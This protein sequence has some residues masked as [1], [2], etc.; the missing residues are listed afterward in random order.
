MH[1]TD[2][3]QL[4]ADFAH[5]RLAMR[6][7]S[8]TF[9][10]ASHLLPSDVAEG[11]GAV[12]AFCRDADDTMDSAPA[13]AAAL[14]TLRERLDAIYQGTP[15]FPGDRALAEIVRRHD[16]PRA[17]FEALLEGFAWEVEGRRYH[18]LSDLYAYAARVA[19]C[20]GTAVTLIMGVRDA[21]TLARACDLGVAMQ[22]TNV[23]RDVGE[24]A[25]AGRLFLPS[26]WL[27]QEGIDADEWLR[28]PIFSPTIGRLVARLLAAAD[29][30]YRRADAGISGLPPEC[31]PAIR[32][33]SR[34]YA[35]IG[36]VI[37]EAGHDSIS[38]RART[39]RGRK[40]WLT[41]R[42]WRDPHLPTVAHLPP[43]DEVRF[44]VEAVAR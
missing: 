31:R 12:Y 30:L 39:S 22:L 37:A 11:V 1:S 5:C 29:E 40:V 6:A 14:A 8:S 16:M 32:A 19:S 20:V 42:H 25:R 21:E 7:G 28:T 43:L 15:Q 33:A 26:D 36:R 24:D 44:L 34:L 3:D 35:D 27:L 23:A 13:T 18:T 17:I 4:R 9:Y 41:L 2:V 38:R 10:A